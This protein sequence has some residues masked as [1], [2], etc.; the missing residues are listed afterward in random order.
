MRIGRNSCSGSIRP[1][2]QRDFRLKAWRLLGQVV[3]ELGYYPGS[4]HFCFA[5]YSA[6]GAFSDK[7]FDHYQREA[8]KRYS[9]VSSRTA[10]C[11][12]AFYRSLNQ[13]QANS[14]DYSFLGIRLPFKIADILGA[15]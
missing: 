4:P 6:A 2:L 9:S 7:Y 10:D 13:K 11:F 15:C 14:T 8:R 5:R 3:A 1:F 12:V